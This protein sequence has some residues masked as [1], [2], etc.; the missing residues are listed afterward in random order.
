MATLMQASHQWASRPADE[1]FTSLHDM[2]ETLERMRQ[3]SKGVVASSRQIDLVP[4]EDHKGLTVVGQA[5]V[6]YAPSHWAFNQ[7]AQLAA[8]SRLILRPMRSITV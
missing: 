1:R 5:G 6:P 2:L 4:E 3:Q 8:R 7:L